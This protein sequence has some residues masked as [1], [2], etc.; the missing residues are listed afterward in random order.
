MTPGLSDAMRFL[1]LEKLINLRDG[2]RKR[3]KIDALDLLLVQERGHVF[4]LSSRCPHQEHPLLEATIADGVITCPLHQFSFDLNSG[5]PLN[6]TC[7]ALEIWPAI[8][9]GNEVGIMLTS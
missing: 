4:I 8:Y 1:P 6:G 5:R 9:E 2:Y 3:Q 7:A